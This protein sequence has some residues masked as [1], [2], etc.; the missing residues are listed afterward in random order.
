MTR[1]ADEMSERVCSAEDA[2]DVMRHALLDETAGRDAALRAL[3]G[4]LLSA[5]EAGE[6]LQL[7]VGTVTVD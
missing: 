2:T 4:R 3:E 5:N 1:A 6:A 7:Q